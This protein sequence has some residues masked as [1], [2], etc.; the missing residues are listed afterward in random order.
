MPLL[1]VPLPRPPAKT[2]ALMTTSLPNSEKKLKNS[3]QFRKIKFLK[4]K[5]KM[6]QPPDEV[7]SL[8]WAGVVATLNFGILMPNS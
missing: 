4:R 8:T 2:C 1:N 3:F 6:N 7:N 5:S